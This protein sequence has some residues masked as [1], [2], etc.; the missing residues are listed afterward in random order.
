MTLTSTPRSVRLGELLPGAPPIAHA[1][2]IELG[3]WWYYGASRLN[4]I[5][6]DNQGRTQYVWP[7][8]GSN[9]GCVN[10]S[11]GSYTGTNRWVV[12]GALLAIPGSAAVKVVTPVGVRL[13]QAMVDYGGYIV[14]GRAPQAG[15]ARVFL[16]P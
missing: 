1:L 10:G 2:K 7:A 15:G 12:P 3:N 11:S 14:D 16:T 4:P 13:K 8:T 6:A 9:A 5:S